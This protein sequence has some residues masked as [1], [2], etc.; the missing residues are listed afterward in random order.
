MF[1]L[2]LARV[3][4]SVAI[5]ATL[6]TVAACGSGGV[7]GG[8]LSLADVGSGGTGIAVLTGFGSLIADGVRRN[9]SAA[10]YASEADQGP[11]IAIPPTKAMLGDS[12][13]YAYDESG[14]VLSVL[15]SPELVGTVTAVA[16][17]SVTV[18]GTIVDINADA[19]MGPATAFVGYASLADVQVGD[20]IEVHGLLNSDSRGA[21]HLQATLIVRKI[22]ATGVR[23]TGYVAQYDAASRTFVIGSNVVTMGSA[24]ISPA[25]SALSNGQLVTVWSNADPAGNAVAAD[26]I[27]VKWPVGTSGN[28]TVSGV[29][30]GYGGAASFRVRNMNVDASAAVVGPGGAV[31]ADGKYVVVAGSFD[32][33]TNKLTATSV[34]AF[35]PAAPTTVELHGTVANFV[36]TSS[37]TVR[38]VVVDASSATFAGGTASQLANGVFVEIHGAVADNLVRAA[39]VTVQALSPLQAPAGSVLDV[40]GVIATYDANTGGYTMTMASGGTISGTLGP[41]LFYND[42]T[43][44]NFV[45]G[46]TVHVSGMFNGGM[47]STSV[48]NFS[49]STLASGAGNLHL[50][51]IAYSVNATSFMLNGVTIQNNG[52][53]I[54]GGA[55][56]GGQGMMAGSRISVDVQVSNGQ[57]LATAIRLLNG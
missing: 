26:A 38:G 49:Q 57:Y 25:G 6:L 53:T 3:R 48:V 4:L 35:T 46:E 56:M 11:A 22:P 17:T 15:V 21:A 10:S 44:A 55:M 5:I 42:G 23:L 16:P 24:S 41:R 39:S 2:I 8:I 13:E 51:G 43:A 9:D 20:R 19:S 36:S 34:T 7:V 27:R 1:N 30:T 18:L 14:N 54:P 52:L 12:V 50:E 29:I 31:L 32:V 33:K 47:L 37:F 45:P 28:V 40:S